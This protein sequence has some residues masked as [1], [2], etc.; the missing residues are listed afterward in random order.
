M[1]GISSALAA[2]NAPDAH[3]AADAAHHGG[4]F[5]DPTFWVAV[6]FVIAV[7]ILLRPVTK[8]VRTVL[9]LRIQ[10]I[11]AK[12][13]DA[14]KLREDA[15][16]LLADCQHKQRRLDTMTKNMQADAKKEIQQM[17]READ[18]ELTAQLRRNRQQ[19]DDH[20]GRLQA[21]VL[22][23]LRHKTADVALKAV[24]RLLADKMT[25]D[26]AN[27]LVDLAIEELPER[28]NDLGLTKAS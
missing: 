5:H 1:I 7:L 12:L 16:A 18:R 23:E 17:K 20:I 11:R 21:Q 4:M 28:L 25:A 24:E 2:Q 3:A 26:Q 8:G 6:S 15:Q 14:R 19:A 22:D 27:Y 10:K 13:D 9:T